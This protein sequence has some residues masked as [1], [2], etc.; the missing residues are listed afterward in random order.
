MTVRD[1]LPGDVTLLSNV[2]LKLK[3]ALD[4]NLSRNDVEGTA[5]TRHR[6]R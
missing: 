2:N 6:R 4:P 5:T 3:K 1:M